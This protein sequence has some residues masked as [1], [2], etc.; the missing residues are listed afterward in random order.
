MYIS[1]IY[2]CSSSFPEEPL[3]FVIYVKKEKINILKS[4]ILSIEFD[5]LHM[6]HN[7]SIF[8]VMTL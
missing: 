5:C 1:I 4:F 7:K 2:A 8:H 3:H 6:S